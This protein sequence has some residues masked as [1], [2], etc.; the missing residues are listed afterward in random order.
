MY[1]ELMSGQIGSEMET[2]TLLVAEGWL[3]KMLPVENKSL[4]TPCALGSC[5]SE[6]DKG[7]CST[8]IACRKVQRR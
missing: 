5:S 1:Y 4:G 6:G 3:W 7:R 2:Q 8:R